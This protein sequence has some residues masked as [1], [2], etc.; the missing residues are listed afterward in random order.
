MFFT[1]NAVLRQLFITNTHQITPQKTGI[2]TLRRYKK[3]KK[4]LFLLFFLYL[5]HDIHYS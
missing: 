5:A 1:A 4:S 3:N 2:F